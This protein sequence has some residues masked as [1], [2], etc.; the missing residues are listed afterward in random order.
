MIE[1]LTSETVKMS[2]AGIIFLCFTMC[3]LGASIAHWVD[4]RWGGGRNGEDD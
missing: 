2:P 3:G 1:W 4:E